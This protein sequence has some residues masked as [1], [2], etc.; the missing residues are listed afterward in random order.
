MIQLL[1]PTYLY[2][3]TQKRTNTHLKPSEAKQK[4]GSG[5]LLEI[6]ELYLF[7]NEETV[8]EIHEGKSL[9]LS[10]SRFSRPWLA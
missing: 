2:L 4:G 3:P 10:F 7:T 5:L 6:T 9:S 8:R 1:C